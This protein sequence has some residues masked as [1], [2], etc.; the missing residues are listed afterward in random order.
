VIGYSDLPRL[1]VAIERRL[2]LPQPNPDT[3]PGGR[4]RSHCND[5]TGTVVTQLRRQPEQPPSDREP[6]G[7]RRATRARRWAIYPVV[8]AAEAPPAVALASLASWCTA[9]AANNISPGSTRLRSSRVILTGRL[10]Q[11]LASISASSLS[12]SASA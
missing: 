10:P 11:L 9:K 12:F 6:G 5:H 7:A 1:A 4:N 3:T 2:H 8:A